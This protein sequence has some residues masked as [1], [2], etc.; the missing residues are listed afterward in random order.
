VRSI[1]TVIAALCV[2]TAGQGRPDELR[3]HDR[4]VA[5]LAPASAA[6]AAPAHRRDIRRDAPFI[7]SASPEI[8]APTRTVV[9]ATARCTSP[10]STV[11]PP[12]PCSRGPPR[13]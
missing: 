1:V 12:V 7:A 13:G 6:I 11:E 3:T 2:A 9:E 4:D 10:V 5:T 8:A